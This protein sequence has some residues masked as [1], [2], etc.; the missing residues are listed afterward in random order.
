MKVF[1]RGYA[2]ELARSEDKWPW[3][4]A[5]K[6]SFA[7]NASTWQEEHLVLTG[8]GDQRSGGGRDNRASRRNGSVKAEPDDDAPPA[9]RARSDG[10]KKGGIGT[11]ANVQTAR[12]SNGKRLCER[13]NSK[14]SCTNPKCEEKHRCDVVLTSGKVCYGP[15]RRIRHEIQR[16]GAVQYN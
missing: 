4:Q 7:D 10:P 15:H 13:F 8:G 1:F 6:Q 16:D 9:T 5:L 14:H 11:N 3:G 12:T 2:I